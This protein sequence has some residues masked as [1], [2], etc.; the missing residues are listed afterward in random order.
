MSEGAEKS[1][2]N[3]NDEVDVDGDD[4]QTETRIK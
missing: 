1:G 3:S 4:E 2:Q